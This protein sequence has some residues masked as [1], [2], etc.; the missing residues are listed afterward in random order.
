MATP[1][2][3]YHKIEAVEQKG[4][5]IVRQGVESKFLANQPFGGG[6]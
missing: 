2:A 3:Q 5:R 1:H 4:R 6:G